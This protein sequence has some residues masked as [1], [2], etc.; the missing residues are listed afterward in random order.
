MAGRWQ[1]PPRPR[2]G[3]SRGAGPERGRPGLAGGTRRGLTRAA[4]RSAAAPA[5]GTW[6]LWR[7]GVGVSFRE[8]GRPSCVRPRALG[9][10]LPPPEVQ[11][12]PGAVPVPCGA[13]PAPRLEGAP[14][15]AARLVGEGDERDPGPE[16]WLRPAAPRG[17]RAAAAGGEGAGGPPS[18][19]PPPTSPAL[20][21]APRPG[22]LPPSSGAGGPALPA[23]PRWSGRDAGEPQSLPVAAVRSRLGAP[24]PSGKSCVNS[25]ARSL[26]AL[27][28]FSFAPP[29]DG[30]EVVSEAVPPVMGVSGSHSPRVGFGG[31]FTGLQEFE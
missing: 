5:A 22:R 2:R 21:G 18:L 19:P 20:R 1:V 30:A 6:R 28:S 16:P 23:S 4:L 29:L 31:E 11:H 25:G 13:E 3:C 27:G 7:A 26:A 15:A 8:T 12:S 17:V 9:P 14:A 10:P 24:A